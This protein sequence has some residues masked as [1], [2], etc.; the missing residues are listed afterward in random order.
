[1]MAKHSFKKF[2]CLTVSLFSSGCAASATFPSRNLG[3]MERNNEKAIIGGVPTEPGRYPYQVR[4]MDSEGNWMCA[5]TLIE[6]EWILTSAQCRL[7]DLSVVEIGRYD[8]SDASETFEE[9]EVAFTALHPNFFLR[10]LLY[11][12]MLV[13]LKQASTYGTVDLNNG[14]ADLSGGANVT[15]IGWGRT[16]DLGDFSDVLLEVE[17]DIIEHSECNSFFENLESIN[18]NEDAVICAKREG[19]DICAGDGGGPLIIK[20]ANETLDV[21]VGVISWNLGGC[22]DSDYPGVYAKV[23]TSADFIGNITT[24]S[25]E[26][27]TDASSF[28]DCCSVACVDGFFTCEMK[29]CSCISSSFIS[30]G[31]DYSK[32][33]V[34]VAK[35]LVGYGRCN[36]LTNTPECNYD[37]GDCCKDTCPID[38][39]GNPACSD[40]SLYC[41]DPDSSFKNPVTTLFQNLFTI[42]ILPLVQLI[43]PREW[44]L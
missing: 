4:I 38:M 32:C 41:V 36:P 5:G 20:G 10:D 6:P 23:N 26:A 31:F 43:C 14:S 28:D 44:N 35:C 1:M 29:D 2:A 11:D 21:L 34:A 19:K 16:G 24:C 40:V 17:L 18:L 15:A 37:G 3:G 30:D 13:R 7:F 39:F 27:G 22:E 12:L 42:F 9:I 25:F 33:D 8:T